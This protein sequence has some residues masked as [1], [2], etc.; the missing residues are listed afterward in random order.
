MFSNFFAVGAP[1]WSG[2][3]NGKGAGNSLSSIFQ[4]IEICHVLWCSVVCWYVLFCILCF[5][6]LYCVVLCC[7]AALYCFVL[8]YNVF[9]CIVL[10]CSVLCLDPT[11][12]LGRAK[13]SEYYNTI[14]IYNNFCT[15]LMYEAIYFPAHERYYFRIV[16]LII[17]IRQINRTIPITWQKQMKNQQRPKFITQSLSLVRGQ[18]W[19]NGKKIIDH[20]G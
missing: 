1:K 14:R 4:I 19:T 11:F 9:W 16:V 6:V 18:W 15:F 3:E 12:L 20:Y 2:D 17:R 13:Y 5:T 10:F 7:F 8:Y